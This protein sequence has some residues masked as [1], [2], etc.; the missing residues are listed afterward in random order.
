[1]VAVRQRKEEYKESQKWIISKSEIKVT[2]FEFRISF[3]ELYNKDIEPV[4]FHFTKGARL[5]FY[6]FLPIV[7]PLQKKSK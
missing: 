1:M 7:A 4:W 6:D 3:F 2:L 5:I